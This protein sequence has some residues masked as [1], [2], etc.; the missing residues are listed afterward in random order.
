MKDYQENHY[1]RWTDGERARLVRIFTDYPFHLER[2]AYL[3]GRSPASVATRL[4]EWGYITDELAELYYRTRE[5]IE[6]MPYPFQDEADR[7]YV[8]MYLADPLAFLK[9]DRLDIWIA[10][11]ERVKARGGRYTAKAW[12][13]L[14]EEQRAL[15]TEDELIEV[16]GA[17]NLGGWL[18]VSP[19]WQEFGLVA[20]NG[21]PYLRQ[22]E[23][24]EYGMAQWLNVPHQVAGALVGV[25]VGAYHDTVD[26]STLEKALEALYRMKETGNPGV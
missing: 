3:A 19:E 9:R 1:K 14:P 6:A 12:Q 5:Q 2:V 10:V 13:S 17:A 24:E 8:A 20:N 23:G 4:A 11:I 18:A 15:I 7:R 25:W 21:A 26:L 16:N 22:G